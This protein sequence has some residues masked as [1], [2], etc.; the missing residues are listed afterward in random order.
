MLLTYIEYDA[1]MQAINN[2]KAEITD[3]TFI[4]P[5]A[6]NPNGY[7]NESMSAA[8]ERVEKKIINSNNPF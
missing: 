4:D 5:Y 6:E 3:D 7:T 8:L 2:A 1:I